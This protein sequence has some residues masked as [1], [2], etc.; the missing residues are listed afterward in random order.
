LKLFYNKLIIFKKNWTVKESFISKLFNLSLPFISKLSNLSLSYIPRIDFISLYVL[1]L[2]CLTIPLFSFFL[3]LSPFLPLSLCSF[4]NII[5]TCFQFQIS[6]ISYLMILYYAR[7]FTWRLR[8]VDW[9]RKN[10][11]SLWLILSASILGKNN[12]RLINWSQFFFIFHYC[13]INLKII[14]ADS[15][16]RI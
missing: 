8:I 11:C 3:H 9:L 6:F 2:S 16:K 4:Y 13:F 10:L 1:S 15:R 12:M 7:V 5:S 14:C